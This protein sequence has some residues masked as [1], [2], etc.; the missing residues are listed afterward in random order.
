MRRGFRT[1]L[2]RPG[3]CCATHVEGSSSLVLCILGG[4]CV[5][6]SVGSTRVA[7]VANDWAPAA[8]GGCYGP[9]GIRIPPGEAPVL[10]C[11]CVPPEGAPAIPRGG[12]CVARAT[13]APSAG[14][15]VVVDT[16]A[17][18]TLGNVPFVPALAQCAA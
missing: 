14:G 9:G 17:G 7:V 18:G 15:C 13:P 4:D 5:R 3:D 6:V 11:E 12:G 2:G 16:A 8:G 1:S 10:M